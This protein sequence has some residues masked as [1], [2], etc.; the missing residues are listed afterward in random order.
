M[1]TQSYILNKNW[2]VKR[3]N[4]NEELAVN[5]PGDIHSALLDA[6]FIGDP[7]WRDTE[8][9]LDWVHE[10]VWVA[11]RF[12]ILPKIVSGRYFLRLKSVDTHATVMVNGVTVG[13]LEN[14]FRTYNLDVTAALLENENRITIRFHSN[15]AIA[16]SKSEAFPFS[17]P[18]IWNNTLSY[19]NFL[20]KPQC[21][22]GWDWGIALSPLGIYDDISLEFVEDVLLTDVSIKQAHKDGVV[23]ITAVLFSYCSHPTKTQ[24]RITIDGKTV[25]AEVDLYP[26][27]NKTTLTIDVEAPQLWWPIGFG[28]QTLYTVEVNLGNQ[29][30]LFQIGLREI[31]LLTDQDEI[32]SRFAFRI[33]GR[34]IFMRG[35][36]W[37]P[38]D[39]LP[40]RA[41]PEI[42]GDLLDSAVEAN[43]NMIRVWGGGTYEPDWFYQ[44]CS[45]RGILVWQDFMFACNLYPSSDRQWLENVRVEARQQVRRLSTHA[46]IALWCGDNELVGA[47]GWFDESKNDRDR[48]IAMYARLNF[49]LQE[50]V[51]DEETDVPWWPSSPCVGHL[52]YGDSW[53][54]DT[55]GDMHFWDVWHS[56]KD[57][58]HYRS[59]KPR[60]CSEF[61]FQSFPSPAIIQSFTE[62][63]DRNISS[64]V[65]N[66]HQK[67]EGGNSRIV[68]TIARYFRFPDNF[69]EMCWLSQVSQALAM[70][71][72][73]EFWRI[74]KPRTMGTIYWQL[75]DTW[76]VASW[77]SLEYGG[78]WKLTHYL[79]RRFFDP[80]FVTAQLDKITGEI[81]IWAINDTPEDVFLSVA[82]N[83]VDVAGPI[84]T[85]NNWSAVCPSDR[86][87]QVARIPAGTLSDQEIMCLQWQDA[88]LRYSGENDYWKKRPKDYNLQE[89]MIEVTETNDGVILSTDRPAFYVTHDF[90]GSDV[91]SD[92]CFVLLPDRPKKLIRN[93]SRGG[94]SGSA[95]V[96][97]LRG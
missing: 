38:A 1:A 16:N 44:M 96:R 84:T 65:M 4:G 29:A 94:R 62:P 59:V 11:E 79:A 40:S 72:A 2:M 61:G 58:E 82:A 93:R 51:E 78:G 92:N 60:F 81:V 70:K 26:G 42:V 66:I 50:I 22:A 8:A 31:E 55:S 69:D 76:P 71:T 23:S 86:S 12:F 13:E 7:Y 28:D 5:F 73:I 67:N 37:I 27:E 87:I 15:S 35:A 64:C 17:V 3:Q 45:E 52:N 90:G 14:R 36:N 20:R 68:E 19:Y 30:K 54:D 74:S 47:I 46:C 6:E 77:S 85:L 21:D 34:E 63:E 91:W 9:T 18:Y 83:K 57:F 89:A 80:V 32:G 39:A 33:N 53:H 56:A 10:S 88:E 24:G 41:T 75:N 48:Y 43:M 25:S 97:F 95:K 49:A